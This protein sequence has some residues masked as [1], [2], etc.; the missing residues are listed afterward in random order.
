MKLLSGTDFT[1]TNGSTVVLTDAAGP[2]DII[3]FVINKPFNIASTAV[4]ENFTA[5]DNQTEFT[6]TQD[7]TS[8]TYIQV[9]INGVKIRKSDFTSTATNTVTLDDGANTGDEV[10][11][12]MFV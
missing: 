2:G 5:T 9:F 11:I 4:E 1:A 10:D 7:F 3:E 6:T 12:V 8:E